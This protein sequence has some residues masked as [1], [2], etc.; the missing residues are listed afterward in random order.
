MRSFELTAYPF[1]FSSAFHW[2][3]AFS[4]RFMHAIGAVFCSGLL[5]VLSVLTYFAIIATVAAY[6]IQLTIRY[7]SFLKQYEQNPIG[8]WLMNLDRIGMNTEPDLALFLVLK[9]VGTFTVLLVILALVRWR[10]RVG[11]PVGLGVSAF[12]LWLACYLTF[13]EARS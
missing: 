7:A 6:D 2:P 10:A 1:S 13:E 11:H 8:R 5:T 12:Q 3:I 9:A 4:R